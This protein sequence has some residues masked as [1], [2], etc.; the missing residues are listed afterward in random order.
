MP[1]QQGVLA[2]NPF[3]PHSLQQHHLKALITADG[4]QCSKNERSRDQTGHQCSL[5]SSLSPQSNEEAYRSAKP[6]AVCMGLPS[7][8]QELPLI[9][10]KMLGV[11]T[12]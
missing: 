8:I 7:T 4:R 3:T 9:H 12:A 6:V 11:A 1:S 10:P 2:T 5:P